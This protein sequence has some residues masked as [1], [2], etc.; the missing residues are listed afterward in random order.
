M[1]IDDKAS[2]IGIVTIEDFLEELVGE[3]WDEDDVVDP[4]FIK[5][6]GNYFRVTSRMTVGEAFGRI[7]LPAPASTI[8]P[9]P[10]ISFILDTLGRMPEEEES[11]DYEDVEIIADEVKDGRLTQVVIH[12]P[13][14]KEDEE[15]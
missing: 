4:D 5:L 13:D 3:I 15:Q 7:G 1:V 12:I 2:T 8:A 14:E 6:G 11:F 9:K 10:L